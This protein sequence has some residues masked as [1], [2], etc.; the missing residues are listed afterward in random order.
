MEAAEDFT[1][2]EVSMAAADSVAV[3]SAARG[4]A[5]V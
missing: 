4:L 1:A 2:E 5:S 3:V